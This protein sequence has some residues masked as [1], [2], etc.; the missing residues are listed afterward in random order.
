MSKVK[1]GLF[2][3]FL[4]LVSSILFFNHRSIND[5]STEV[6]N[7]KNNKYEQAIPEVLVQVGSYEVLFD[8]DP[9]KAFISISPFE[10][11]KGTTF[12]FKPEN[13]PELFSNAFTDCCGYH[14][15]E[16]E[17]IKD[18]R[19]DKEFI[20]ILKNVHERGGYTPRY[21]LIYDPEL[22]KV[23]Y[24]T[25]ELL[26][27]SHLF[28]SVKVNDQNR[29]VRIAFDPYLFWNRDPFGAVGFIEIVEYNSEEKK[30]VPVGNKYPGE[31]EELLDEQYNLES[32]CNFGGGKKSIA[33]ILK[34]AGRDAKCEVD[35]TDKSFADNE[36]FITIGEFMDIRQRILDV[37]DGKRRSMLKKN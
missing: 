22:G 18:R 25:P 20:L 19:S 7:T 1:L 31:F 9:D 6:K 24:E 34:T 21:G 37:I 27:Y 23:I 12:I 16:F 33:E 35:E 2:G 4:I 32:K 3:L 26:P 30:F 10:G 36:D 15:F 28:S 5:N 11:S 17:S 8:G 13:Y 29:T 14:I